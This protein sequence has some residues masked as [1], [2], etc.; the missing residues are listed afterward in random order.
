MSDEVKTYNGWRS[1]ETWAVVLH[2]GNDQGTHGCWCEHAE[3]CYRD[4]VA[5][6][7]DDA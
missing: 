3:D 2:L 1:Y 7:P 6:D 4:A 5:A